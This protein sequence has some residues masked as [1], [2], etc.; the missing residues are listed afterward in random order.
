[1]FAQSL[2]PLAQT[3][4]QQACNYTFETN[5]HAPRSNAQLPVSFDL[6]AILSVLTGLKSIC[7]KLNLFLLLISSHKS[8]NIYWSFFLTSQKM[9]G[10]SPQFVR[11]GQSRILGC[12]C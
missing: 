12:I 6:G 4:L 5:N 1:L 9:I 11:D 10:R 8:E 2:L 7:E 3:S